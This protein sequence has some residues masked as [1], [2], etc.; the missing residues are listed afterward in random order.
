M[1]CGK[2]C[3]HHNDYCLNKIEKIKKIEKKLTDYFQ[4]LYILAR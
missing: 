3:L 2:T 1:V 4:F